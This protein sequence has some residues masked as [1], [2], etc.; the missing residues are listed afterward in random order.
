MNI[1]EL[2][3]KI[4]EEDIRPIKIVT[5]AMTA[6]VM[7]FV[8]VCLYLYFFNSSGKAPNYDNGLIDT[9]LIVLAVIF[10][11][12]T[13]S[14]RIVAKSMLVNTKNFD[15]KSADKRKYIGLYSTQ[16]IVKL[17]MVEGGALF[18]GVVFL[19]SVLGNQIYAASYNWL[20]LLPALFLVIH[21]IY[22]MP[23][24]E[25]VIEVLETAKRE[26]SI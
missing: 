26:T 23:T 2:E 4:T 13:V 17:A 10:M 11:S 3:T 1:A 9:M 16:H 24:K 18:G 12:T 19:L 20:S 7:L 22:L 25:K 6:G 15:E 21:N 8:A 5:I 14:S